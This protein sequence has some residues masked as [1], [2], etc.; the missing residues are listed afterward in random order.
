PRGLRCDVA[1]RYQP[2]SAPYFLS[3]EHRPVL[4]AP[5]VHLVQGTAYIPREERWL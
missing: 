3:E 4:E 5:L 1:V 2:S